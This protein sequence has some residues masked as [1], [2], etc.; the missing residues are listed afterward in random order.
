M[1]LSSKPLLKLAGEGISKTLS[2]ILVCPVSK[3]PLRRNSL[4]GSKRRQATKGNPL[5]SDIFQ[6]AHIFL[7]IER[8]SSTHLRQRIQCNLF[9]LHVCSSVREQARGHRGNVQGPTPDQLMSSPESEIY[10]FNKLEN[11]DLFVR[12]HVGVQANDANSQETKPEICP[13]MLVQG[14]NGEHEIG[15]SDMNDVDTERHGSL[16]P[17]AHSGE[18]LETQELT[19]F[20]WA[21]GKN[22]GMNGNDGSSML[23]FENENFVFWSG[24][25]TML[26]APPTELKLKIL[27]SL[28][29]IDI[30]K[31]KR[32]CGELSI[33]KNSLLHI[34]RTRRSGRGMSIHGKIIKKLRP[35]SLQS[36]VT[37]IHSG[38]LPL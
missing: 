22:D 7:L 33:G 8:M 37:L 24:S 17:K 12:G 16:D 1:G 31:M 14:H 32:E 20:V 25:S 3:Q 19:N 11:Q 13:D 34:G 35:F 30:A 9:A 4:F 26:D 38:F 21:D 28:A 36:G 10:G 2:E 29:A 15:E 27:E 6:Q 5:S 18:T 23:Y